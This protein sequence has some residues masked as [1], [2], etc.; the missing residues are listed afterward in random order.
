MGIYRVF[1]AYEWA[2]R[3]YSFN[4]NF[5]DTS[6]LATADPTSAGNISFEL[7]GT[8][9][10]AYFN[11]G[12]RLTCPEFVASGT[13]GWDFTI[14]LWY[15]PSQASWQNNTVFYI[16]NLLLYFLSNNKIWGSHWNNYFTREGTWT[17]LRNRW[18]HIV[19]VNSGTT[20][21]FYVDGALDY[22]RDNIWTLWLGWGTW[23]INTSPWTN[24]NPAAYDEFLV[25]DMARGETEILN[26]YNATAPAHQ[27]V[28]VPW[29]YWNQWL[30][31][32]SFSRDGATRYTMA[33]KNLGASA[34][35]GESWADKEDWVGNLY[36]RW[37]CFGFSCD[38]SISYTT[39]STQVDVSNYWPSNYYTSSTFITTNQWFIQGLNQAS[40]LWWD[41][42]NTSI[43]RQGPCPT[44]YHIMS[45]GDVESLR[46]M[47]LEDTVYYFPG[48]VEDVFK[49]PLGDRLYSRTSSSWV[50]ANGGAYWTT[51]NYFSSYQGSHTQARYM[52]SSRFTVLP[53]Y[54]SFDLANTNGLNN[55]YCIRPFKDTP[56]R[57]DA[58]RDI[59][60][61]ISS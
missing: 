26:Y 19:V 42:T 48:D 59:L 16:G 13:T 47:Y 52:S 12:S 2:L 14:S 18:H 15:F 4:G 37:N 44:W 58:S 38:S 27:L 3:Q 11:A 35:N 23:Y 49:I 8:G 31:L 7:G 43:A 41:V 34:V 22:S 36:Q 46:N 21:K 57:P 30:W 60:Y 25:D 40:D 20:L 28:D 33:D 5:H 24:D 6:P 51:W 32:I 56:V 9:W 53:E 17:Y 54:R 50:I 55:A 10:Y 1:N 61:Q 29:V 39:S 45:T